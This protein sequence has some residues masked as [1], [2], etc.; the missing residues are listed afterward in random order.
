M[1]KLEEE[2][3]TQLFVRVCALY[4]GEPLPVSADMIKQAIVFL[5]DNKKDNRATI[6][7]L[8]LVY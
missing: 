2:T 6:G 1:P 7:L 5:V 3:F 4:K 8:R